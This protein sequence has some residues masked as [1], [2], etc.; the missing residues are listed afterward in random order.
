MRFMLHNNMKSRVSGSAFIYT[1]ELI[2]L[3]DFVNAFVRKYN[4]VLLPMSVNFKF[5]RIR[6]RPD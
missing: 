2:E 6:N 4:A 1:L 3:T 5:T